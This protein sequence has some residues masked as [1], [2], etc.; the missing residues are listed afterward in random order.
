[1]L[2]AIGQPQIVTDVVSNLGLSY[3]QR[4]LISSYVTGLIA[5]PRKTVAGIAENILVGPSSRGINRLLTEY[6][7]DPGTV[8]RKRLE[9]L[10]RH[11]E[12]RWSKRGFGI[13]DDTLVEKTGKQIPGAGK[14]YDHCENKYVWAQNIVTLHY[15]DEKTN[16]PVSERLYHKKGT[17]GFKTKIELAIEL[18]TEAV[19]LGLPVDE[20]IFDSWYLS[21]GF[22]TFL[23]SK[24]KTWISRC[25]SDLLV[26]YGG[27]WINIGA[28][29]EGIKEWRV[30]EVRNRK[31]QIHERSLML[32]SLDK[33]IRI[34]VSQET[35]KNGETHTAFLATNRRGNAEDV[36]ANYLLR[37]KIDAFYKDAKQYLGFGKCQLRNERG[38]HGHL[39]AVFLAHTILRLGALEGPLSKSAATAYQSAKRLMLELVEQFVYFVLGCGERVFE[40]LPMLLRY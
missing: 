8:N 36:V 26:R 33:K 12:T 23:E 29:A 21:K 9:E 38:V 16:Y 2:P 28:W 22:V 25:K 17:E 6:Q 32:K 7:W 13:I 31:F 30:I 34:V 27:R 1:M 10:Q 18:I 3:H 24:Q 14:L 5:S 40:V 19:N 37:G 11:N 15:A 39:A 35:D 4:G 20:Y